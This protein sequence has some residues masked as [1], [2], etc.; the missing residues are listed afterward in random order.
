MHFGFDPAALVPDA[1]LIIVIE[2]DVP[3]YPALT[4]AGERLPRR[5][6]RRRPDLQAL[7]DAL[8]PER[9]RRSR[10]DA[11]STFARRCHAME[12]RLPAAKPRIEAR[13]A[14]HGRA[15]QRVARN[16]PRKRARPATRSAS[17]RSAT[18][19]AKRCRADAIL[20]NESPLMLEHCRA[21]QART[22][23]FG[24]PPAGG[25]GWG[26]G[27]A[28]GAKLA[29]PDKLVVA[30]L[31]DGAYLFANPTVGHWLAA[32]TTCRSSPSSST[33]AA[34]ARCGAR[35]STC[36][37]TARPRENDGRLFADLDPSP[38]FEELARVHGA[39][40]SAS[41]GRRTC[42]PRSRARGTPS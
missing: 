29:A 3:W 4:T 20:F 27:A 23:L 13:R 32:P 8:V 17:P 11:T 30:A 14:R 37:R 39:F 12:A 31:G 10:R 22:P 5:A 9:S 36:S 38:A 16:S 33:T 7:S 28:L 40:A 35:A 15:P 6:Y 1:D 21:R 2:C 24:L 25:L 18:R 42:R 41:S 34:M 19:S 26:I